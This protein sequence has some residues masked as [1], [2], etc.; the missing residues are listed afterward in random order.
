[1][2]QNL[3]LKKPVR[4]KVVGET[5]SLTGEFIRETH[6]VLECTQTYLPGNQPQK[7]PICL[8]VVAEV[9]ESQTRDKQVALFPL[10]PLPHIKL[11]SLPRPGEYLRLR[12]LNVTSTSRP[13]K[14]KAQM[15][16][17]SKIQKKYNQVIK[18]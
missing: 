9:T 5:P 12:L 1:M 8:W 14:K 6:R 3:L 7:S 11:S 16:H 13:K 4:V 10:R 17:R 18:R 15:K 2:P